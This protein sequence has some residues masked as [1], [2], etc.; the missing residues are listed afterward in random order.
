MNRLIIDLWD[1]PDYAA[2]NIKDFVLNIWRTAVNNPNALFRYAAEQ[3]YNASNGYVF[4]LT[5]IIY[6]DPNIGDVYNKSPISYA[7]KQKDDQS[8]IFD[9]FDFMTPNHEYYIYS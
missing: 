8:S 6:D 9:S 1:E 5:D 4:S 7:D 3:A 2:V